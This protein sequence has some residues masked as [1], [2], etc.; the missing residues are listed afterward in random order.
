MQFARLWRVWWR[1]EE[2]DV[3][4]GAVRV[5]IATCSVS[6]CLFQV[7]WSQMQLERTCGCRDDE[8]RRAGSRNDDFCFR[9][10]GS[11]CLSG[12]RVVSCS[13]PLRMQSTCS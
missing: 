1:T 2:N 12:V 3:V 8:R 7:E 10:G 5:P 13:A 11:L 6:T 4:N 9:V